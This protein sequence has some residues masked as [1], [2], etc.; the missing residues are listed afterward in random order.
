MAQSWHQRKR[1]NTEKAKELRKQAQTLPTKMTNDPDYRRLKYV[2]YADDFLLGFAGPR[3]EAEAIKQ[4]LRK[5]LQEEQKIGTFRG[6]DTHHACGERSSPISRV[7][8]NHNAGRYQTHISRPKWG[9]NDEPD[10][11]PPNRITST[12]RCA[13]GED[14]TLHEER[15]GNTPSG[16]RRRK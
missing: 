16:S 2:R 9:Q 7:C 14:R 11:Q 4:Q 8:N 1:G 15:Q 12:Q 3:A 10:D 6:K 13:K 5:F